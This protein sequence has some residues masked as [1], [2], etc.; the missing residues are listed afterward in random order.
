MTN[1]IYRYGT[2]LYLNLT[3]RCPCACSFCIRDRAQSVGSSDNLWLESEPTAG[4]VIEGLV[5][6]PLANCD[7]VVFCGFGE[8]FC[9]FENMIEVCRYLR[10]RPDAPPVRINTNGLGDLINQKST[11]PLLAGLADVISISLNAPDKDKYYQLCKPSFGPDSFDAVL[12]FAA[13]C[14]EFIPQVV[15]SVVDVLTPGEIARCREI[16]DRLDI[17][18]RVRVCG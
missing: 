4:Q 8:P 15:F 7:Q 18:L 3:N 6:I 14:K 10:G 11:P 5:N 2:G 17:P 16:A 12:L 9:A 1:V 13:G